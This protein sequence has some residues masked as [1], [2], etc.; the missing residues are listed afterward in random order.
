MFKFECPN[1]HASL[2]LD[3][4]NLQAYCPYCGTKLM[5]DIEQLN[6][7]LEEKEKTKRLIIEKEN[8]IKKVKFESILNFL[9]SD[10]FHYLLLFIAVIIAAIL[11]LFEKIFSK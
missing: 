11:E 3:L 7:I 9:K 6:K 4:D 2:D 5:L 8:E 10:S 1:C